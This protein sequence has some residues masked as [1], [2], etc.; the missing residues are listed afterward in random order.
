MLQTCIR[1]CVQIGV[2]VGHGS[3]II[4][5]RKKGCRNTPVNESFILETNKSTLYYFRILESL[6]Q[7]KILYTR[8][9]DRN[10]KLQI[11]PFS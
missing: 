6:R 10:W 4:V 5:K 11:D 3:Y 8:I 1:L 7:P 9:S 2:E